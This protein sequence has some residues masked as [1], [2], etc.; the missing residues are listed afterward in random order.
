MPDQIGGILDFCTISNPYYPTPEMLADIQARLPTLIK[1]YPSCDQSISRKH[2][3]EVIHVD[4]EHLLIGNGATEFISIVCRSLIR[5]IGI[6]IPTFG[7]YLHKLK[8][9]RAARLYRLRADHR[10][11][12]N[13][14]AYLA[15]ARNNGL[16]SLIVINPAN[17]TGQFH[18]LDDLREFLTSAQDMDLVIV[19]ESFIDFAGDPVPSLL[20]CAD[21]FPNLL[22]V[23]SMGKHCGVPGLRLGYCYVAN[24]KFL[25]Q[26]QKALPTWNVNTIAEYFLSLL[27]STDDD[28]HRTRRMV[29]DDIRA[30]HAGLLKIRGF[31]PYPSGA[32]FILVR[33][34]DDAAG[35]GS[36][37][38]P[39]TATKL[40]DRL[41]R[42]FK[43]YVCDCT[44]K[45][46][47]DSRHVCL[48]TQGREKDQHLLDAL[49]QILGRC[50]P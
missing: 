37:K 28:Y 31:T 6:A 21:A 46:G 45:V 13:L 47:M 1:S 33:M 26:L 35:S 36:D 3:A 17:P 18:S 19:D 5:N 15:W 8:S 25:D 14:A 48:A 29:I 12:L 50:S 34:D 9:T 32:N 10:Y 38:G 42:D 11:Q 43:I 24:R 23:R 4:P 20:S 40:C 7:D 49:G 44:N 2:L 22:V 30:L 41:A 27:P 16:K 39:L